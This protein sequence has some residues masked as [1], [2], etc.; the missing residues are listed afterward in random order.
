MFKISIPTIIMLTKV[1]T[2]AGCGGVML[3]SS[4]ELIHSYN[5]YYSSIVSDFDGMRKLYNEIYNVMILDIKSDILSFISEVV[6]IIDKMGVDIN[7]ISSVH[8]ENFFDKVTTRNLMLGGGKSSSI[9]VRFK[10]VARAYLEIDSSK[11]SSFEKIEPQTF[12]FFLSINDKIKLDSELTHIRKR[13]GVF[14]NV[15]HVVLDTITFKALYKKAVE[16]DKNRDIQLEFKRQCYKES[17]RYCSLI[18]TEQEKYVKSVGKEDE[19]LHFYKTTFEKNEKEM[20]KYKAELESLE[21]GINPNIGVHYSPMRKWL[22]ERDP[23]TAIK[24]CGE[25]RIQYYGSKHVNLI[26]DGE[27]IIDL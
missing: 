22:D 25:E 5:K 2:F 26:L 18:K 15:E 17:E 19:R 10:N 7:E 8:V 6:R 1:L 24:I 20:K 4:V 3:K 27:K 13:F 9:D 21:A 14:T 11:A 16:I 12:F 23:T